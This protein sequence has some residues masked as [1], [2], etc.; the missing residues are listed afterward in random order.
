MPGVLLL[1]CSPDHGVD[2]LYLVRTGVQHGRPGDLP[3][4]RLREHVASFME[5]DRPTDF[6]QPPMVPGWTY[7][8]HADGRSLDD[9]A[10]QYGDETALLIAGVQQWGAGSCRRRL[11]HWSTRLLPGQHVVAQPVALLVQP[12]ERAQPL[13]VLSESRG[14]CDT[15]QPARRT[16][17]LV[18]SS[19]DLPARVDARARVL[20]SVAMQRSAGMW[21]APAVLTGG[22]G[23]APVDAEPGVVR[24]D[25]ASPED[26]LDGHGFTVP[27]TLTGTALGSLTGLV[28]ESLP[29]E[30]VAAS[31]LRDMPIG[32]MDVD[33]RDSGVRLATV[34]K[35]A[36]MLGCDFGAGAGGDLRLASVDAGASDVGSFVRACTLGPRRRWCCRRN[37]MSCGSRRRTPARISGRSRW[38]TGRAR[39]G[40]S[41]PRRCRPIWRG[42]AL[43]CRRRSGPRRFA[44]GP[45]RCR[46]S[47]GRMRHSWRNAAAARRPRRGRVAGRAV[48]S[49]A[50]LG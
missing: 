3:G 31:G 2:P 49:L 27:R 5:Q 38:M 24:I 30:R 26:V 14:S 15:G 17:T 46:C 40:M 39:R 6:D 4:W 9:V 47:R 48:E 22:L 10:R 44:P 32:R 1:Q 19:R 25:V 23:M 43:T 35:L 42:R 16:C 37:L 28:A 34:R 21:D 11:E 8:D 7:V 12:G 33:A 45:T 20:V 50:R 36:S 18:V 41:V 13:R 29:G